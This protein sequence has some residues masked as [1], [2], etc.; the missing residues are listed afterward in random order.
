MPTL[1]MTF[2][3]ATFVLATFFHIRNISAITDLDHTF[4]TQNFLIQIFFD[5]NCFGIQITLNPN[6]FG[7]L[8]PN[9]MDSIFFQTLTLFVT[10]NY[11]GPK[12]L[13]DSKLFSTQFFWR[14]IILGLKNF[15]I[16]NYF[17]TKILDSKYFWTNFVFNKEFFIR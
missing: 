1:T 2:V 7:F 14:K 8:S 4:W 11:F 15:L 3:K 10:Q 16:Q 5:Q 6:I 12:V 9:F 17:I 13:L